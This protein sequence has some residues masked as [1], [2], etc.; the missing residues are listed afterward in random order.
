PTCLLPV[1]VISLCHTADKLADRTGDQ[2]GS[3]SL[4]MPPLFIQELGPG[5]YKSRVYGRALSGGDVD[6][7]T[8]VLLA[9]IN[10]ARGRTAGAAHHEKF[11]NPRCRAPMGLQAGVP[12]CSDCQSSAAV[13]CYSATA[14]RRSTPTYARAGICR[15][16]REEK[17]RKLRQ[18]PKAPNRGHYS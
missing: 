11:S 8:R 16:R 13:A 2:Y 7:R 10:C 4:T 1:C 14:R 6:F 12:P 9:F 18:H 3:L 5:S 15:S 17:G